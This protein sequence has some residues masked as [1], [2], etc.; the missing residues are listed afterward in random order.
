MVRLDVIA[1]HNWLARLA[2][3]LAL[4]AACAPSASALDLHAYWDK[5]CASCHGHAA[6]FARRF[7]TVKEGKLQGRHHVENLDVFLANHYLDRDLIAPATEMLKA[8]VSTQPRFRTEC[9]RCHENA[10]ALAR[11]SLALRD[12]ILVSRNSGRPTAEFLAGHARI[13]PADV[14]FFVDVL[15][16]VVK[17][18]GAQ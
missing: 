1:Q 12:G 14:P 6:D 18:I 8:Q 5:N 15:S 3:A 10:A 17:E 9:G 16:R 7:L 4:T 11:D 2:L 13:K